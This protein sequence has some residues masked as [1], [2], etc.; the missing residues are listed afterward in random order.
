VAYG[1][2]S[3]AAV[4]PILWL[5]IRCGRRSCRLTLAKIG[6]SRTPEGEWHMDLGPGPGAPDAD[7]SLRFFLEC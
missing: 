2:G 5:L 6:A 4:R 7:F 1:F 3:W